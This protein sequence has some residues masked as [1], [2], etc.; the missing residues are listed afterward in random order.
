MSIAYVDKNA[1]AVGTVADT[2]NITDIERR[3]PKWAALAKAA[4]TEGR[5]KDL[6][7]DLLTRAGW[8]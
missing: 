7:R 1:D 5:V 8:I 6:A 3:K 2:Y 4:G